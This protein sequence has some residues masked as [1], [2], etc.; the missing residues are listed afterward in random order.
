ML[1]IRSSALPM[2]ASIAAMAMT[3]P[4]AAGDFTKEECKGITGVA[5][6]VFKAMD[7]STLSEQFRSSFKNWIRPPEFTCDGPKNIYTPTDRD[8]AAFNAIRAALEGGSQPIFLTKV[9]LRSVDPAK[10]EALRPD[11]NKRSEAEVIPQLH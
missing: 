1:T 6:E 11:P 7:G 4:A 2:L 5:I 3:H 9:G 10:V 8:I